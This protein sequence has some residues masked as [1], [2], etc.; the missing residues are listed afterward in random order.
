MA[1]KKAVK[2]SRKKSVAIASTTVYVTLGLVLFNGLVLKVHNSVLP[3]IFLIGF[4]V[5]TVLNSPA[6]K[7]KG[8]DLRAGFIKVFLQRKLSLSSMLVIMVTFIVPLLVTLYY[9]NFT[10][11]LAALFI[12]SVAVYYIYKNLLQK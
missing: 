1:K 7:K 5:Y 4:F 9:L 10:L 6:D 3:W 12:D 2:R 8:L 11:L